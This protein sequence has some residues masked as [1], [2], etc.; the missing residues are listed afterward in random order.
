LLCAD[1]SS[2]ERSDLGHSEP[3]GGRLLKQLREPLANQ[4]LSEQW[5]RSEKLIQGI[6]GNLCSARAYPS[7]AKEK[8]VR[9]AKPQRVE[10]CISVGV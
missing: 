10:V 5:I 6:R 3:L 2:E 7:S 4:L 8:T 1:R 9:I